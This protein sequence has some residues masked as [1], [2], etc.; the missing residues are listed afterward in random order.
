VSGVDLVQWLGG[1]LDEDERI[2]REATPGPWQNVPTARHHAT[3]SGRSEEAVFA[4]PPD[5]GAMV[6]AATGEA[7]ERRNLINAEFIAAHDPARVLREIEAKRRMI[8]EVA[9]AHASAIDME[10]AC[11]HDPEQI[12]AGECE[13]HAPNDLPLLRLL[14]LP[15]ADRPG[16]EEGWA[17]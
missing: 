6:V 1:Q 4:S 9:A 5:T 8:T 14:A 7:S 2:A 16:Y 17:P 10:H 15:Y 12:L 13:Q 11:C 3:A